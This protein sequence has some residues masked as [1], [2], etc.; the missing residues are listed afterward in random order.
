MEETC[1]YSGLIV[2]VAG[3]KGGWLDPFSG[4][5]LVNAGHG[6]LLESYKLSGKASHQVKGQ[7][8]IVPQR[9]GVNGM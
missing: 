9:I 1:A 2:E 4:V 6:L 7:A 8:K 3:V 5:Q